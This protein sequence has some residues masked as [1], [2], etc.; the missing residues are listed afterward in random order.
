MS[1]LPPKVL[2]KAQWIAHYRQNDRKIRS[3][4]P[5][6]VESLKFGTLKNSF[7]ELAKQQEDSNLAWDMYQTGTFKKLKNVK[8]DLK[9][10]KTFL[11]NFERDAQFLTKME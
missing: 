5:C 2:N 6:D 10:F 3:S 11:L 9:Q 4:K 8:K 1:E 7:L